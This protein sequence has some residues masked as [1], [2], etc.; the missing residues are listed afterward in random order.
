[1]WP[2]HYSLHGDHEKHF[3]IHD[4]RDNTIF[5]VSKKDV[6]PATQIKV[7]K[8]QKFDEGGDVG[9]DSGIKTWASEDAK[10]AASNDFFG[11]VPSDE[12]MYGST[13]P[14]QPAP[15]PEPVASAPPP[16]PIAEPAPQPQ[17]QAPPQA[18]NNAAPQVPLDVRGAPT[19]GSLAS[20]ESQYAKSKMA[21]AQGQ[22]EQNKQVGDVYQ[23][24][25]ALQE[26]SLKAFQDQ[27]SVLM[28]KQ[29]KLMDDIVAQKI[30][31][32]RLWNEKSTG[33]K[34]A[35]VLSIMLSGLGAGLQGSDKNMA[36]DVL[37]KQIDKDVDSQ[38]DEL[39]KKQTLLSD[40]LRIHGNLIQAEQ[41][42]RL[43][44]SAL[45]QAQLAQIAAQSGSPM[46]LER[47]KQAALD[48]K[49]ADLP[50]MQ[51]LAQ[52]SSQRQIRQMLQT[53]DVSG[54]DPATFIQHV[55]PADKQKEVSEE[56]KKAQDAKKTKAAYMQAFDQAAKDVRFLSG[57]KPLYGSVITPPSIKAMDMMAL[58]LIH[59]KEGRVN[60]YE[61]NTVK[62]NHPKW[63]ENDSTVA[64]K[65]AAMENFFDQKSSAPMA[66]T[67]GLDLN[68]FNST[69][70]EAAPQMQKFNGHNY[71][72]VPGGWKLAK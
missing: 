37:Q 4:S 69:K 43:Q 70:V 24:Q 20:L 18:Q 16:E 67:Y 32:K 15:S 40:N 17:V 46:I 3:A 52:A 66:K 19:T 12:Q 48:M 65:R 23:K 60:E 36:I 35:S 63:G 56:I 26:A 59:D 21:E 2:K 28:E 6:H 13:T 14:Q 39:G 68:R 27:Q 11:L 34:I 45:V 50:L 1:M 22:I 42:T 29:N 58:P 47:A 61:M 5:N 55:V 51:S 9:M 64:T 38:K 8:M 72:R 54:M 49:R 25:V 44:A 41:A 57:G 31:P 30:D 7:M 71:V 33:N 10:P 62:E 53:Q